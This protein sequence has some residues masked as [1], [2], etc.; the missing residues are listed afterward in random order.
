MEGGQDL[1]PFW[2]P[3]KIIQT[4]RPWLCQGGGARTSSASERQGAVPHAVL[5]RVPHEGSGPPRLVFSSLGPWPSEPFSGTK[6]PDRETVYLPSLASPRPRPF[7]FSSL[8]GLPN[9]PC[10]VLGV[11]STLPAAGRGTWAR[12]RL[13]APARGPWAQP[14]RSAISV[15]WRRYPRASSCQPSALQTS[16]RTSPPGSCSLCPPATRAPASRLRERWPLPP[17]GTGLPPPAGPGWA[18]A[19][20]SSPWKTRSPWFPKWLLRRVLSR[21]AWRTHLHCSFLSTC[22]FL[23]LNVTGPQGCHDPQAS[24]PGPQEQPCC[25]PPPADPGSM[26]PSP[27]LRLHPR[28]PIAV[29]GSCLN[30]ALGIPWMLGRLRFPVLTKR[31]LGTLR[32]TTSHLLMALP[33]QK[34]R[35]GA[36]QKLLRGDVHAE[37]QGEAVRVLGPCTGCAESRKAPCALLSCTCGPGAGTVWP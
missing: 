6:E 27:S 36:V 30:K 1:D 14:P 16:L 8:F 31:S 26:K 12:S 17:A 24:N 4:W 15:P 7:K 28:H 3:P 22:R 34:L 2:A 18:V 21:H 29:L 10:P 19:S 5:T 25:S 9:K 35:Q 11:G 37:G 23:G 32:A 13:R 33:Q 20:P